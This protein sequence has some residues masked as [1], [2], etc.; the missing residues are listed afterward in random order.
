MLI[1]L[2]MIGAAWMLWPEPPSQTPLYEF[3][4]QIESDGI[5]LP[6]SDNSHFYAMGLLLIGVQ[7]VLAAAL[8][9]WAR[10]W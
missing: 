10:K 1:G 2:A 9:A 4:W 8:I 6:P 5:P 3:S 7:V